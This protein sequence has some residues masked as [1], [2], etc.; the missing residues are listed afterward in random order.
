[1]I[2]ATYIM[3]EGYLLGYIYLWGKNIDAAMGIMGCFLGTFVLGEGY[4]Y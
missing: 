4:I 2:S 1:M 3:G